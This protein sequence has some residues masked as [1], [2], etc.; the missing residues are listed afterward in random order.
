[1]NGTG[2]QALAGLNSA[3]IDLAT[4]QEKMALHSNGMTYGHRQTYRITYKY[5]TYTVRFL[6]K[7]VTDRFEKK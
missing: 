6:Q 2:S 1:M 7:L 3:D 5:Y 4:A